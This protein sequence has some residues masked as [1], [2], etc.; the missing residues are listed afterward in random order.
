MTML[1]SC[2]MEEPGNTTM[3]K[4]WK[5][6]WMQLVK[7]D[8]FSSLKVYK[9]SQYLKLLILTCMNVNVD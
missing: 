2:L 7:V 6:S 4:I 1:R 5:P 8:L 9:R 3:A